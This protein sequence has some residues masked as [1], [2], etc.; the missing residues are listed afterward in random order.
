MNLDQFAASFHPVKRAISSCDQTAATSDSHM[1]I[2]ATVLSANRDLCVLEINGVQ[3]EIPG[4]DVVD[5]QLAALNP[6]AKAT[7]TT[8]TETAKD[9]KAP[10]KAA[11]PAEEAPAEAEVK[12]GSDLAFLKVKADAVLTR[13]VDV[14]VSLI[15]AMGTWVTLVSTATDKQ[16]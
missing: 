13:R 16:T 9:G 6:V 15:A 1:V 12:A 10:A 8:E 5:I 4:Q 7:E 14:P 3:Y 11:S 2:A